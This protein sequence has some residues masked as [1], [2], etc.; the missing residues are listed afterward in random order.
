[1]TL[2]LQLA[3]WSGLRI[4]RDSV[5]PPLFLFFFSS[6]RRH[7]RFK[8]DWSSDVALPISP[9]AAGPVLPVPRPARPGRRD[10]GAHRRGGG[11][12]DQIGRASCR[13]RGEVSGVAVGLG[14]KTEEAA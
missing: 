2:G 13:E 3:L 6:R 5:L 8:C 1:A 12:G 4:V 10:A 7:T 9:R 11:R 14:K